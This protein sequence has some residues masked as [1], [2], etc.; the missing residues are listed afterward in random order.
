MIIPPA[1]MTAAAGLWL[2][3]LS[4]PVEHASADDCAILALV[5]SRY[6]AAT[7]YP[8]WDRPNGGVYVED[9]PWRALGVNPP[10]I[11]KKSL[12]NFY[13]TRPG[14]N[15]IGLGATVHM[16]YSLQ[17]EEQRDGRRIAPFITSDICSF[18]KHGK[19]WSL[20]TCRMEAIT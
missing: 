8:E 15:P 2:A 11:G 6:A 4:Q 20:V 3:T 13:V 17:S 1:M 14:Y 18:A 5:I 16:T 19:T 10:V 12:A 7:F 9:C